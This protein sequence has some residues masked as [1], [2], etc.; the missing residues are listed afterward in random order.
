MDKNFKCGDFFK[1]G[2]G[3]S[4]TIQEMHDYYDKDE[5]ILSCP[6]C[7]CNLIFYKVDK[8]LAEEI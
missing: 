5:M 1:E 6:K 2:C 8:I 4:G 3:W 7:W